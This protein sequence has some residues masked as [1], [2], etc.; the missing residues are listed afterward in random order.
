ML[1]HVKKQLCLRT[2]ALEWRE[3]EGEIVALDLQ[4]QTYLAINRS[5]AALWPALAEGA[6]QEDLVARLIAR[7]DI[8]KEKALADVD[9]FLDVLRQHDLLEADD[10][11]SKHASE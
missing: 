4:A 1:Q 5:G 2:K 6:T 10:I 3:V 11:G 9:A 8:D 7:F